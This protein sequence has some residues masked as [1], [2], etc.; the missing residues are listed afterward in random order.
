MAIVTIDPEFEKLIPK[1][2]SEDFEQLRTNIVR[3]GCRDNLRLWGTILLDGHNRFNICKKHNIPFGTTYIDLDSREDALI[4]IEQ[5]QLGRRNLTDDQ[6]AI[7]AGRLAN[8]RA[9]QRRKVAIETAREAK[10]N[11]TSVADNVSATEKPRKART[12][13]EV[14]KE[15]KV[16]ERKVRAAQKLEKTAEGREL[17]TKV[18]NGE[19]PLAKAARSAKAIPVTSQ[20]PRTEKTFNKCIALTLDAV[21]GLSASLEV[22]DLQTKL[23]FSTEQAEHYLEAALSF[24][25]YLHTLIPKLRELSGN[26]AEVP[27]QDIAELEVPGRMV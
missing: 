13:E 2:S 10:A 8:R 20:R 11:K 16:P 14:S 21:S 24:D 4:W 6:R 19:M 15:S 7:V 12:V 1:L 22:L 23:T 18:L 9:E 5:N 25:G 17:A 27:V 3:D 26:A